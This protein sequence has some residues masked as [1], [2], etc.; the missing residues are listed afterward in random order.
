MCYFALILDF[1]IAANS[2]LFAVIAKFKSEVK[3]P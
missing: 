2:G 3:E 1:D